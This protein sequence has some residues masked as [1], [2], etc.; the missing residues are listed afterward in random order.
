M[1]EVKV[2]K[3]PSRPVEHDEICRDR[4]QQAPPRTDH[5]G[6][7][8]PRARMGQRRAPAAA[9]AARGWLRTKANSIEGGTSEVMLNV[10]AKR[11]LELPGSLIPP[12]PEAGFCPDERSDPM[13]PPGGEGEECRFHTDD[14]AMLADTARLHR[15]RRRDQEAAAPLARRELQGRLRPRPVVAVRRNGPDRDARSPRPTAGSAWAM[16]RRASC[17]TEIGRNLTPSPFLTTSV[18][19]RRP[20]SPPRRTTRAA[21]GC[22]AS[23]RA[24]RARDRDRRGRQAP[25]R[26]HRHAAPRRRATASACRARRTS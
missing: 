1:D 13:T 25:P 15:R 9:H 8:Q 22:R 23:S 2:G 3:A 20:R 16:S 17:S 14:Q 18:H 6:R 12:C 11:I 5:G 21:A 4:A 7:R 24:K 26:T 19:G 10:I